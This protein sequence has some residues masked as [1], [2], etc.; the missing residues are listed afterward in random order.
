[1]QIAVSGKR[2]GF[3]PLICRFC[4]HWDGGIHQPQRR[5]RGSFGGFRQ[6]IIYE[7]WGAVLVALHKPSETAPFFYFQLVALGCGILLSFM[8]CPA[9]MSRKIN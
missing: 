4:P 5:R 9:E 6:K 3:E 2:Q 8:V 7:I 1:M